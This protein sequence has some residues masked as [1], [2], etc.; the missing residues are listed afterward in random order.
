MGVSK[1]FKEKEKPPL[2]YVE[3]KDTGMFIFLLPMLTS[4]IY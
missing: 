2:L 1:V 3:L 4:A